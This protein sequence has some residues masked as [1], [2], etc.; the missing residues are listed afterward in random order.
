V[1]GND[2]SMFLNNLPYSYDTSNFS[3]ENAS[4]STS[5]ASN[6]IESLELGADCLVLDED[7]CATNFM[8]RDTRMQFLVSKDMEPITP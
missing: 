1:S 8:V 6:I 5:Q 3:T 4:G 7:T 2:I